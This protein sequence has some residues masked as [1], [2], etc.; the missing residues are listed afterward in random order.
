MSKGIGSGLDD[1]LR[2]AHET[3][4]R[5]PVVGMA[6]LPHGSDGQGVARHIR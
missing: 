3:F 5:I 4:D 1:K 6:P 2:D